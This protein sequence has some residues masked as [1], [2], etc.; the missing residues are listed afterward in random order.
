VPTLRHLKFTPSYSIS[1]R[2]ILIL[3]SYVCLIPPPQALP[4]GFTTT[5]F[6]HL[7]PPQCVPQIHVFPPDWITLAIAHL[8]NG[9]NCEAPHYT[10]GSNF[11]QP[12]QPVHKQ[13]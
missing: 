8:V 7:S 6:M 11:L 12:Q 10:M 5:F 2:S 13:P 4:L 9:T 1:L 3:S